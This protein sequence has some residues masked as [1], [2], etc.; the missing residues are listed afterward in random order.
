MVPGNSFSGD[1]GDDGEGD[2]GVIRQ[3]KQ[4]ECP[5]ASINGAMEVVALV[6]WRYS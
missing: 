5:R 6:Q 1:D 2:D 3:A 4:I